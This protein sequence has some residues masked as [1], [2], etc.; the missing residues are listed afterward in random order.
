MGLLDIWNDWRKETG[1][2]KDAGS[3][4]QTMAQ[5]SDTI[6][7]NKINRNRN[8]GVYPNQTGRQNVDQALQKKVLMQEHLCKIQK[9]LVQKL[10]LL[11][12]N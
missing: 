2:F 6:D 4:L 1:S 11:I 7:R 10:M 5:D 9:L 8:I 3:N 12:K